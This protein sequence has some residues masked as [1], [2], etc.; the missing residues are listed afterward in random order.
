MVLAVVRDGWSRTVDSGSLTS[1]KGRSARRTRN[2]HPARRSLRPADAAAHH[3]GAKRHHGDVQVSK[4]WSEL[5]NIQASPTKR[6]VVGRRMRCCRRVAE[7]WRDM[8]PHGIPDHRCRLAVLRA[9]P[10]RATVVRVV[11]SNALR[12]GCLP[13]RHRGL[14]PVTRQSSEVLGACSPL[15]GGNRRACVRAMR[16]GTLPAAGMTP[17]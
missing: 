12:C 14:N 13:R 17:T 11:V 10:G 1:N 8:M 16:S 7:H 4:Q 2:I 3:R 15:D 9:A 5:P 6:R